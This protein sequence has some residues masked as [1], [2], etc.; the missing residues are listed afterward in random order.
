MSGVSEPA[1]GRASGLVLTSRFLVVLGRSEWM[2][3]V[4]SITLSD[5]DNEKVLNAGMK[6]WNHVTQFIHHSSI[7]LESIDVIQ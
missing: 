3:R 2:I 7:S 5:D 1:N 4:S 6:A